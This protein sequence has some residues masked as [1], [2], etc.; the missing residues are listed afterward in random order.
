MPG[1]VIIAGNTKNK[2][3]TDPNSSSP[4]PSRVPDP[5]GDSGERES[6]KPTTKNEEAFSWEKRSR[7]NSRPGRGNSIVCAEAHERTLGSCRLGAGERCLSRAHCSAPAPGTTPSAHAMEH[8]EA[9]CLLRGG[10][11]TAGEGTGTG[12]GGSGT[13]LR[14]LASLLEIM[15]SG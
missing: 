1:P 3:N 9:P 2:I 13:T 5:A 7:G 14:R 12:G 8:G 6:L 4:H 10:M 15:A 11:K